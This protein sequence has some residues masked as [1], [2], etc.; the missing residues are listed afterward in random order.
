MLKRLNTYSL[1]ITIVIIAATILIT[2]NVWAVRGG[3]GGRG[4]GPIIYVTSQDLFFD[5]IVTANLPA[6]GPFQQLFPPPTNP[7]YPDLLYL[8]TEFGPGDHDY[9][10]G[11]WWIDFNDNGEMDEGD[12]FFS[13]PLLGPGREAP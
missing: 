5:S 3:E 2:G 10:G 9:V 8:S 1:L 12:M 11:R 13:C 7:D 6:H 4:D